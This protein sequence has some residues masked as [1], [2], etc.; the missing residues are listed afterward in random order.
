M[1]KKCVCK[2]PW[3]DKKYGKQNRVANLMFNG[4]GRCTVCG[5]EIVGSIGSKK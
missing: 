5:K 4:G 3:Q 2:H 1:I